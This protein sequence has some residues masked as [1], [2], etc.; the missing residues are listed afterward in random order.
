MPEKHDVMDAVCFGIRPIEF[1]FS[2]IQRIN[3]CCKCSLTL[4][5]WPASLVPITFFTHGT[6]LTIN[7]AGVGEQSEI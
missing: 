2:Y 7:I 4:I 3:G 6:Y 5:T 1:F